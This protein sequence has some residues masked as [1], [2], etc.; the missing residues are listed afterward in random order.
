VGRAEFFGRR[1]SQKLTTIRHAVCYDHKETFT[2]AGHMASSTDRDEFFPAMRAAADRYA[3][4]ANYLPSFILQEFPS[5]TNAR[6]LDDGVP[7]Y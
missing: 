6:Y 7:P 2:R 4:P 1:K 5:L 3:S